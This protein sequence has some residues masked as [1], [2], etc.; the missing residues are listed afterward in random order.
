MAAQSQRKLFITHAGELAH[1]LERA[2]GH[3]GLTAGFIRSYAQRH[4]RKTLLDNPVHLREMEATIGREALLVMAIEVRRRIP[5]AFATGP[6]GTLRPEEAAL[7]A[8]FL[9]EFLASLGRAVAPSPQ[10]ALVEAARFQGDLELYDQWTVRRSPR[11]GAAG[12]SAVP[13]SPFPDR[14]ALLLDPP[15][16]EAARRFAAEF[17]IELAHQGAKIFDH[18]GR[19]GGRHGAAPRHRSRRP[20]TRTKKAPRRARKT[21]R[22]GRMRRRL[23]KPPRGS[24]ATRRRKR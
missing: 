22:A 17:E 2:V 21:S 18:L 1:L 3:G 10:E 15:L 19:H 8:A 11:R 24:K 13:E 14:C 23:R 5:R 7:A 6:H 20:K 16:M 4:E 9:A 12:D